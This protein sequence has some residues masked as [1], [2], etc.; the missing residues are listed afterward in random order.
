MKNQN[1]SRIPLLF[2][3]LFLY[4]FSCMDPVLDTDE[5]YS[6][7]E[8]FDASDYLNDPNEGFLNGGFED[9]DV[10]LWGGFKFQF[11]EDVQTNVTLEVQKASYTSDSIMVS[12]PVEGEYYLICCS[13]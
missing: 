13:I 11:N 1:N 5:S 10:S 6:D 12:A 7:F 2:T 9:G 4:A 8:A 3:I